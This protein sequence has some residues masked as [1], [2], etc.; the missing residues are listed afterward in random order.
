MTNKKKQNQKFYLSKY[1]LTYLQDNQQNLNIIK[2]LDIKKFKET[3]W[4]LVITCGNKCKTDQFSVFQG[5]PLVNL[6]AAAQQKAKTTEKDSSDTTPTSTTTPT[7]TA[8]TTTNGKP[9]TYPVTRYLC[10]DY[11][12]T[13]IFSQTNNQDSKRLQELWIETKGNIDAIVMTLLDVPELISNVKE[14]QFSEMR[15]ILREKDVVF[16]EFLNR[17]KHM[18]SQSEE[19]KESPPE[20]QATSAQSS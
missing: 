13:I 12:Q 6:V 3:P 11:S 18:E 10:S 7:T 16:Q 9:P 1:E 4:W 2:E 14:D 5:K 15:K 8:L 20:S 19:S 17:K